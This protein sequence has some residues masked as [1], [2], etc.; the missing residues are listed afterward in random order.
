M[1][2]SLVGFAALL[3]VASVCASSEALACDKGGCPCDRSAVAQAQGKAPAKTAE[4]CNCEGQSDCT[5]KK[6]QCKCSKCQL[7]HRQPELPSAPSRA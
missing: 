5:C 3:A 4:R 2:R 7:R 6:G 1:I